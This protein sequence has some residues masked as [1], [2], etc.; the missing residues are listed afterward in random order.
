M[1]E[2]AIGS[3][4]LDPGDFKNLIEANPWVKQIEL[5]NYGEMFLNPHL[6][7][8]MQYAW[9]RKVT[10]CADNGVNLNTAS[11]EVLEG[12]VKYR[13]RSMSCSIDGASPETY[14]QYRIGGD[15]GVVMENI[16]RI[17]SLKR[18]YRSH[19]P[20]LTWQ[21][22]IFGHNEHEIQ[23]AR[24]RALELGMDFRL[25]LSWDSTFSPVKDKELVRKKMGAASR[26]EYRERYGI[27]YSQDMCRQLWDQPCINWDGKIL[28]CAR[29][30]WG[31]F[32]GNAFAGGL[33]NSLNSEGIRYARDMIRGKAGQRDDLP[34][35]T[36]SIYLDMKASNRYLY[37]SWSY[38]AVR[39]VY[40]RMKVGRFLHKVGLR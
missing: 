11:E 21:F 14:A 40:R 27:E 30:F 35:A 3:G 4:F 26:E 28:G 32:G 9:E 13:F 17:V 24:R 33:L 34:C 19:Y 16:G 7:I 2:P 38:V 6:L 39:S 37:H 8:M 23:E 29:N 15:F 20:L 10:L 5:S 25:K 12:L 22:V 18:R 1:T 36:C 31:D